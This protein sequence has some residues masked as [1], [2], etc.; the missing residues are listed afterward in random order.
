MVVTEADDINRG[1]NAERYSAPTMVQNVSVNKLNL[2]ISATW[3]VSRAS[4]R[5]SGSGSSEIYNSASHSHE[6]FELVLK[7]RVQ[8]ELVTLLDYY[9]LSP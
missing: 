7:R 5:G 6:L 2:T 4:K 1:D 3:T 9:Y 8:V